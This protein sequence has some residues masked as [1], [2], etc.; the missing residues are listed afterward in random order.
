[1]KLS[2]AKDVIFSFALQIFENGRSLLLI[3]VI[4]KTMGASGYGMWIQVKIGIAFFCPF[5]LL[6]MGGGITRFMPGSSK[7]E[8]SN[9][10]RS[11][12]M[13]GL[14][15][16]AAL[17]ISV[18]LLQRLLQQYVSVIPDSGFFI[19]GL[20]LLCIAEPLNSL[21]IE[22]FRAFRRMRS[23]LTLSVLDAIFEFAPVFWFAYNGFG[24]GMVIFSFACGRLIMAAFKS[25]FVFRQVGAG[26]FD[27]EILKRYIKFGFPIAWAY[28]F[29]YV[30]NYADRYL[31]GFFYST[32]EVGI[33]SLAYSIGYAAILISSPL[34]RILVPTITEHWNKGSTADASSHFNSILRHALMLVIPVIVF[35]SVAGEEIVRMLSTQEFFSSVYIIPV[36]LVTF[37]IFEV[38]VF[39][40][41]MVML[42]HPSN[43]IMKVYGLIAVISVV[44]NIVLIPAFSIAGAAVSLLVTYGVFCAMFYNIAKKDNIALGFNWPLFLKCAIATIPGL[45]LILLT[46]KIIYSIPLA[47]CMYLASIVFLGLIE[48]REWAFIK[49]LRY[50]PK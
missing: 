43:V 17:A 21:Y 20:A 7:K 22:Y 44:L 35:L 31:I 9:G 25:F 34:D 26:S 45:L 46:K 33:Y 15:T 6:G 10:M 13:S 4:A 18:I 2:Y 38:G 49:R 41:R 47:A 29:F 12:V 14:L 11:S 16:G 50:L 42:T 28:S 37:L 30:A 39:Y 27:M 24:I 36:M 48:E 5:L 3:P 1:M 8:I 19:K 23:L 40:Q 32:K